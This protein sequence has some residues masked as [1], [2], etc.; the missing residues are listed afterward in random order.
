[1]RTRHCDVGGDALNGCVLMV[2]FSIIIIMCGAV[3]LNLPPTHPVQ[4]CGLCCCQTK[5]R[6]GWGAGCV[7]LNG[8]VCGQ[9]TMDGRQRV[10]RGEAAINWGAL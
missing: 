10:Q 7:R 4:G 9:R 3:S 6:P 1:M 8:L 5:N 2:T